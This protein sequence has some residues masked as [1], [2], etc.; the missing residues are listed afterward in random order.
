ML[1]VGTVRESYRVGRV[2][3]L[4]LSVANMSDT[5]CRAQ[6]GPRVQQALIYRGRDRLSGRHRLE[7]AGTNPAEDRSG[8]SVFSYAAAR[9]SEAAG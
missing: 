1:F 4:A 6:L 3:D 5:T 8:S 7:A 9:F 2:A